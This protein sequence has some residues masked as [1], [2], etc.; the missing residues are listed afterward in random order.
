MAGSGADEM[1]IGSLNTMI[2]KHPGKQFSQKQ[3]MV[4]FK[5]PMGSTSLNFVFDKGKACS[6][7]FVVSSHVKIISDLKISYGW[8]KRTGRKV[9]FNA[10]SHIE[11]F[12]FKVFG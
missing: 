2:R 12:G 4:F 7:K 10:I 3:L 8:V 1:S 5:I 9:K 11:K 6:G